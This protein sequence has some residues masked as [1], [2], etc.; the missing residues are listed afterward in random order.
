MQLINSEKSLG[1]NYIEKIGNSSP[2]EKVGGS[3]KQQQNIMNSQENLENVSKKNSSKDRNHRSK[4]INVNSFNKQSIENDDTE[5]LEK[6]FSNADSDI[7]DL[8]KLNNPNLSNQNQ[9][10]KKITINADDEPIQD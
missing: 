9:N 6:M 10:G 2:F 4:S 7:R 1:L 8:S 5:F 3:K